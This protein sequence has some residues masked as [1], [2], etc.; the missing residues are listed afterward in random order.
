MQVR[1]WPDFAVEAALRLGWSLP[2][3]ASSHAALPASLRQRVSVRWP[4]VYQWPFMA[5]GGAQLR[6]M[7]QRRV[8]VVTADLPQPYRGTI[9]TQFVI[10]GRPH[11][12]AFNVSDYPDFVED[13]CTSESLLT[14]KFQFREDGYPQ[15]TI[16]PGGYLPVSRKLYPFLGYLRWVKSHR[17]PAFDVYGRFSMSFA[18]DVRGQVLRELAGSSAFRFWGGDRVVPYSRYLR[19]VARARVCIDLPGTGPL[20]MRLVEYLAVGACVVA[21]RH[22]VRLPGDLR[23]GTHLVCWSGDPREAVEAC[24]ALLEDEP[25]RRAIET[26]AREF[27][28][29]NLHRDQLS[30]YYLTRVLAA[31]GAG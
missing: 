29:R 27:F 17:D 19:E 20:C 7:L 2:P 6:D 28:D 23:D 4:R 9:V 12:V 30:A 24:R 8:E 11:Q 16:I 18:A 10:D 21:R 22:G 5:I 14:F 26:S 13:Q 31:A 3:V 1:D 25:R 15:P